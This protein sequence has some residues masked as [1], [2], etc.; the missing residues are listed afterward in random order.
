MCNQKEYWNVNMSRKEAAAK[1]AEKLNKVMF[2]F[3]ARI[4]N[5]PRGKR[6]YIKFDDLNLEY[7]EKTSNGM[8]LFLNQLNRMI[9]DKSLVEELINNLNIIDLEGKIEC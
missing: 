4:S 9:R 3:D 8:M 2:L 6:L 7:T 1:I 5:I